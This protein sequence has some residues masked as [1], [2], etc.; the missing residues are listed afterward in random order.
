MRISF[1]GF[2]RNQ[3]RWFWVHFW[4]DE[5]EMKMNAVESS[6]EQISSVRKHHSRWE[7]LSLVFQETNVDD[8]ESISGK[9]KTKWRWMQ[10][11]L[12]HEQISSVRKHHSRWEFLSLVFQETNVDDSESISGKMKT[13]WRWMQL[14]LVHEQ[15]S[16]VRIH[17]SRWEFLSL[18]FQETNV[19]DSESISGKMKTKWR[20]MQLNLVRNRSLLW[21][22]IILDEN[23]FHWFSKKP[24]SMILSPFLARWRRNEDECSWI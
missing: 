4:Q 3:C 6:Y 24:M 17:H 21:E 8:S 1:I 23:F 10:L 13:K 11:N 20:W 7:F 5:D 15:I 19:D 22:D 16:S 12:V 2:P 9:M 18:V 14:N